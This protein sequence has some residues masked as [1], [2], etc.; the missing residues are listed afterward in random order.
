MAKTKPQVFIIESLRF[1]DE[2]GDFFEGR[3]ISDMLALSGKE[4]RYFYV[5][6][7]TEFEAVLEKF[8]ESEYRYLHLSAHANEDGMDTTLDNIPFADLGV[9]LEPY[10][11]KRR[12][13]LSACKMSCSRLA[14]QL[15]PKTG[16]Y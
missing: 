5:R 16:C 7:K 15:I 10:L 9:M 14:K 12:L 4:C 8:W 13:F 1:P 2:E 6:T 11:E 3:R